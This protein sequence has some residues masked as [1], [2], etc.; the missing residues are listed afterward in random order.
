LHERE[1]L[2]DLNS[3]DNK[4]KVSSHKPKPYPLKTSGDL[5]DMLGMENWQRIMEPPPGGNTDK[6][7]HIPVYPDVMLLPESA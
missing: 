5:L 1:D 7:L 2:F 6:D 4:N 3:E